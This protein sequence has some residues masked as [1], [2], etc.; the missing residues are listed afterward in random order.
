MEIITPEYMYLDKLD[1]QYFINQIQEI[2]NY[3]LEDGGEPEY[4]LENLNNLLIRISALRDVFFLFAGD[5]MD[6]LMQPVNEAIEKVKKDF[7]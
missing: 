2:I 5:N 4:V 1:I 3:H 7:K 6:K